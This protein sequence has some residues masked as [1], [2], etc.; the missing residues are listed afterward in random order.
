MLFLLDA[1]LEFMRVGK[2]VMLKFVDS[3]VLATRR[4]GIE[5]RQR[6]LLTSI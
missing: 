3:V 5:R 6:K 2:K 1:I 4:I